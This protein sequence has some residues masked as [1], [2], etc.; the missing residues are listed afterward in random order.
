MTKK[1][2]ES[3]YDKRVFQKYILRNKLTEDDHKDYLKSLP[4]DAKNADVLKVFSEEENVLTFN[5]V[6]QAKYRLKAVIFMA[7]QPDLSVLYDRCG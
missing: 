2:D 7:C 4:D 6:E 1:I 3:L 5:S